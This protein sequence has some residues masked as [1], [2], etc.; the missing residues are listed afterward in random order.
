MTILEQLWIMP[1][2]PTVK[3]KENISIRKIE[4]AGSVIATV[5]FCL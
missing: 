3:C 5:E 4:R 2:E 1:E